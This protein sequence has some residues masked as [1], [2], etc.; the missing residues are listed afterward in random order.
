MF[1][2][3]FRENDLKTVKL[4][5]YALVIVMS[6]TI[7]LPS[8]VYAGGQRVVFDIRGSEISIDLP[9]GHCEI[10][11]TETGK[12]LK[13]F[14][15]AG[16]QFSADMPE[17]EVIFASCSGLKRHPWGWIGSM[18]DDLAGVSQSM[19]NQYSEENLG[20]VI[21]D[22]DVEIEA[23]RS[24]KTFEDVTGFGIENQA[25]G[26]PVS[27]IASEQQYLF[28]LSRS[29]DI[30]GDTVNEMILTSSMVRDGNVIYM[31]AYELQEHSDSIIRLINELESSANSLLVR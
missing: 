13:K 31:Y 2:K 4:V 30:D 1:S 29:T 28:G 23:I 18:K 16:G 14:L 22:L 5:C 27:L 21:A 26:K 11:Q 3:T 19:F 7:F 12:A 25:L 17:V 15:Q 24:K 8:S 20:G 6:S 10:T 9:S